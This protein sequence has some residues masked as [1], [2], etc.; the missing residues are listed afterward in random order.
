MGLYS[1]GVLQSALAAVL[2]EQISFR[3]EFCR[4]GFTILFTGLA[5]GFQHMCGNQGEKC[6]Q[7]PSRYCIDWLSS[8]LH[9]RRCGPLPEACSGSWKPLGEAG[10][11]E[12]TN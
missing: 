6:L 7:R 3:A 12:E 9:K 2:P 1:C 8:A 11:L 10:N 4:R 5:D